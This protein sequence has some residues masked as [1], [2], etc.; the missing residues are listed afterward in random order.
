MFCDDF[1]DFIK[2]YYRVTAPPQ[3]FKAPVIVWSGETHEQLYNLLGM[4]QEVTALCFTP[5]GRFL[6]GA[7]SDK[8]LFLWDMEVRWPTPTASLRCMLFPGLF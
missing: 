6:A 2:F 3:D 1:S 5:D 7:S 4:K 8:M